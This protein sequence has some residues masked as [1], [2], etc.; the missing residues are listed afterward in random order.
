[1][2]CFKQF[3]AVKNKPASM[4]KYNSF[5]DTVNQVV[6]YGIDKGILHLYTS[7]DAFKGTRIMLKG[8]ELVNFG[9]CSYLG[10]EFDDRLKEGAKKAIDNF[11][12]QFSES[13]AYVSIGL[14]KEL[15]LLLEQVFE[16]PC[17]I[18]PTTTLGHI[19]NI[20]VMVESTHAVIM[21]QQVH[22]SV[23][24]AVEIVKARGV[25]V[26]LV[27][28]NRMDLLEERILA[29]RDKHDKIWYM[30]DGIYSM[31]GDQAPVEQ[32]RQLMDQYPVLHCYFDDAHGMGIYGK[33]GR[34]FVLGQNGIHPRMVLATSLNKAFAC[35]GGLLVY[36]DA[37]LARKVSRTGAPLLSS[38]PMQPSAL[39][40]GIAAARI[41]LTDEIYSMQKALQQNIEYAHSLLRKLDLPVVS[42]SGA[43]ILF[44]GVSLPKLGHNLVRRMLDAGYYVNLGIFP[45][46]PIKQTGIRFT[47][48]RLHSFTDIHDMIHCLAHEFKAA[49]QEEGISL[50]HIQK[51]F[52]RVSNFSNISLQPTEQNSL[53]AGFEC[54]H[55]RDIQQINKTEWDAVFGQGTFNRDNLQLLQ[56]VFSCNN[57]RTE[58]QWQFDYYLVKDEKGDIITATFC[59]TALWKDDMLSEAKISEQVEQLRINNPYAFTSSVTCTGSLITEG[60]HLYINRQH[61]HWQK[62]LIVLMEALQQAKL[63]NKADQLVLRDFPAEDR[64]LDSCMLDNGFFRIQMP[65]TNIITALNWNTPEE[66]YKTLSKNS[67]D[68]LRKKVLKYEAEFDVTF[69]VGEVTEAQL[70]HIYQ[71]YKAVKNNSLELNTFALPREYFKSLLAADNW[72]LMQLTI[73]G[74][75][76][77]CCYVFCYNAGKTYLPMVIGMDYTNNAKFNIYRQALYQ[78]VL[79]AK[80][81]NLEKIQLGF[82]ANKE[83]Q[84]L[85]A[86]S[87]PT[88]GYMS[89]QDSFNMEQLAHMSRGKQNVS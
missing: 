14:Y 53:K 21:D 25:H 68:Q 17:V 72:E 83:K 82:T 40:A 6:S 61:P 81:L 56:K 20:P 64:E 39:G 35:G 24:T 87:F 29:L 54:F 89:T 62:A 5:Y 13:R 55:Y 16:A 49:L 79:R 47:I 27:R 23:Q 67:K 11:G 73:K 3:A 45:T 31:F 10:L 28:H 52:H 76:Q 78:L 46:V 43:A 38:G 4:S 80:S 57:E 18:A 42:Q 70:N 69:I 75:E 37:A 30:A 36:G 88:V 7:Q 1:M 50:Q 84:K 34:G 58:D 2:G 60:N 85:G 86:T 32:L 26:E 48:T 12:T 15:Q 66:F 51:A 41:L 63:V 59:T 9:S 77:P 74:A 71:L 65:D 44:V 22:N 8:R 19:A 33:H